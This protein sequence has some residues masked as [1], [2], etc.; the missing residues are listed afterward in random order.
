MRSAEQIS[1]RLRHSLKVLTECERTA[2]HRHQTLRAALDWGYALLGEPE[3]ALFRRLSVFAGGFT[4]E[5]AESVGGAGGG[6]EEEDVLEVLSH[7]VDKS[8]VVAEENWERGARYRLLEPVRQYG[9]EKLRASGVVKA[10]ERR[11]AGF[12]YDLAE[13][14]EPELNEPRQAEWMDRL[15]TEHE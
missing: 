4:L 8:L 3:Q 14:D 1:E 15:E 10:V 6:I 12:F 11:N 7:L 2:D 5:A 13:E 9:E